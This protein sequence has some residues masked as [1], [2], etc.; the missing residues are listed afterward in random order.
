MK[1]VSIEHYCNGYKSPNPNDI[2]QIHTDEN[3]LVCV[4]PATAGG[5]VPPV[6]EV[7][8]NGGERLY[9]LWRIVGGKLQPSPRLDRAE[10]L[11]LLETHGL[12]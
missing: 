11:D 8:D 6:V 9:R 4:L 2:L 1:T 12:L 3:G 7:Y 10:L 5:H